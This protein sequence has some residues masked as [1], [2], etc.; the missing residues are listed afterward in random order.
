M[1]SSNGIHQ[2]KVK[3]LAGVIGGS[4]MVTMGALALGVHQQPTATTNLAVGRMTMAATTT[5]SGKDD[6]VEAT[7]MAVPTI[8]G[9]APLPTEEAAAE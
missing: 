8:K 1:N 2:K 9:P 7:S 5:A 3:I 6:S 4:A